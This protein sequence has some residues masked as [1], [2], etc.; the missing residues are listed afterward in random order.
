MLLERCKQVAHPEITVIV[1]VR[2]EENNLA[3]VLEELCQQDYPIDRFEIL[4]VDGESE[5]RT[6]A[7]AQ[8]FCQRFPNVKLI[9]NN[10]RLSSSARNLGIMHS[11]GTI[12]VIVDG[13][14][15]L[16]N[17]QY[18]KKVAT[19][20][21]PG[22]DC[23][24]R[25]QPLKNDGVSAFGRAV[26]AAR[27]SR[28]GHH[29]ASH[30]Y[31]LTDRIV[32]AASVAVAYRKEVFQ[33]VGLFNEAFDACEDVEFNHR[34]DTAGFKCKLSRKLTATYKPRETSSELLRQMFRYG[35]GRVRLLEEHPE[36]FHWLGLAPGG[37]IA[38]LLFVL[39][40]AAI[41]WILVTVVALL[42]GCYSGILVWGASE[43]KTA[44]KP[45]ERW[46]IALALVWIHAGA[47]GGE[48]IETLRSFVTRAKLE[49]TTS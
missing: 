32:P 36:T 7:V 8:S 33:T 12:I 31:D 17:N 39:A 42:L 23:L 18:L 48:V 9:H 37:F 30:V 47:G 27:L 16:N 40:V 45:G 15:E 43:P 11:R 1:P 2:N 20:L 49:G 19:L 24:G 4:I 38:G 5:D 26:A 3:K 22:I 35:I 28:W 14:C 13:H 34:V 46:L 44:R 41:H 21:E 25:P 29:P 6:R 10:R